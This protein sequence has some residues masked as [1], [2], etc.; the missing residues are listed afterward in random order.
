MLCSQLSLMLNTGIPL[1][2]SFEILET[3]YNKSRLKVALKTV[4]EDVIKGSSIHE[5]MKKVKNI[6]PQ[7]M[8]ET[9]KIGE[10]AGR[11]EEILKR[12]SSY[13]EKQYNI[14]AAVKNALTYPLLILITSMIVMVYLM[15]KIIPQ[16]VDIILSAG[17]EVPILTKAVIYSCEFLRHHYMKICIV[18]ILAAILLHKLSKNDKVEKVSESIK[19]KIPY[20]KKIYINLIIFKICSS[21][22]ILM[23]SGIN[24]VKALRITGGLLESKVMTERIEQCVRCMEQGEGIYSA[25]NRLQI[26]DSIFLSL[27]KTGE[28]A[29]EM[30]EIFSSLEE[31]FENDINR[32]FKRLTKVIEPVVIIFLSLFVGIFVIA[33]LMPIFSIMD[34][35][36]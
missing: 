6:F 13:Y 34:T 3:Q 36:L 10:E 20:F 23:K 25:L 19:M 11:L 26:N 29:G 15:T 35:T 7:F 30:E 9:V 14:M 5:S 1:F 2:K 31:L 16:F 22:S 12:L 27:I 21:M 32:C 4:K 33:A 17:G 24:I 18:S 28:A 8:I